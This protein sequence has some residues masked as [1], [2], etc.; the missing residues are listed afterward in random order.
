MGLNMSY[1][2]LLALYFVAMF[3]YWIVS[4]NNSTSVVGIYW[5]AKVSRKSRFICGAFLTDG[6]Y[7]FVL[8]Q[9][10]RY[11]SIYIA[12]LLTLGL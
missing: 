9:C 1:N 10:H 8:A 4:Y 12:Y 11:G 2:H 3:R 5:G 7:G 6:C